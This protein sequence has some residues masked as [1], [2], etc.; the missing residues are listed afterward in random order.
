[1]KALEP[2]AGGA[3]HIVMRGPGGEESDGVGV[4]L[5]ALP[6]Q[7]L[8]FTNAFTSG[9][10]PAGQP[11]VVLF[12]ATIVEMFDESGDSALRNLGLLAGQRREPGAER[13]VGFRQ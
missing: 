2:R 4:F 6:E 13:A 3:S 7:R 10:I 12:M 9:W 1:M 11:A 8:V 5:E